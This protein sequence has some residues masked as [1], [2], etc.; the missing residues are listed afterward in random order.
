MAQSKHISQLSA[1]IEAFADYMVSQLPE[2]VQTAGLTAVAKVKDRVQSTGK[3]S[4]GNSF[5]D[6]DPKYKRRKAA[7]YGEE[8]ARFKNFTLT[9]NMWR[10]VTV[11]DV[12]DDGKTVSATVAARTTGAQDKINWNSE[13][14]GNILLLSESENSEIMQ[15]VIA[16]IEEKINEYPLFK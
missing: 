4:R 11:T 1:D 12:N 2:I 7:R 3:D 16:D 13:R 14:D 15:D 6:Y 5:G 8:S 9:G 10:E